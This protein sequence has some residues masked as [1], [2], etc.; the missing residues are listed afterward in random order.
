MLQ[1]PISD[2]SPLS[3]CTQLRE[4]TLNNLRKV[5]SIKPLEGM[6]NL[7]SLRLS[8][9]MT[10]LRKP[11]LT[12]SKLVSLKNLFL[13][14]NGLN[15][16]DFISNLNALNNITVP[17]TADFAAIA[18]QKNIKSLVVFITTNNIDRIPKLE[19]F[20]NFSHLERLKFLFYQCKK[21]LTEGEINQLKILLPNVEVIVSE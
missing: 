6:T 21:T 12:L 2:L 10:A 19:I 1:Q 15:H 18:K 4:V 9:D 13:Q 7:E 11:E 17:P 16:S 3:T 14:N 8:G 5:T 20:S